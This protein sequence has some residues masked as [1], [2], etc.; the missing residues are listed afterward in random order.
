MEFLP[1]KL[2]TLREIIF[3]MNPSSSDNS[4]LGTACQN[5]SVDLISVDQVLEDSSANLSSDTAQKMTPKAKFIDLPLEFFEL[6]AAY[7]PQAKA[8]HSIHIFF[9]NNVRQLKSSQQIANVIENVQRQEIDALS[10]ILA[11]QRLKKIPRP[12]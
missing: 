11:S 8:N 12:S 6:V 5:G 9:Q 3:E 2:K 10:M 7:L 4:R 1:Q